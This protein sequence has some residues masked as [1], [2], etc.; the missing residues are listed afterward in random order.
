[1]PGL[2]KL[3]GSKSEKDEFSMNN[4]SRLPRNCPLR[5]NVDLTLG[6]MIP[7]RLK[8]NEHELTCQKKKKTHTHI[9][10]QNIK[11]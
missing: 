10:T 2:K 9:H 11:T 8:P 5:G 4:V 1:M 7:H 3:T 6:N